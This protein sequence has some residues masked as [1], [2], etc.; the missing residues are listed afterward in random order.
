MTSAVAVPQSIPGLVT[1]D[2][3]VMTFLEGEQIT[4]LKV[5]ST[6]GIACIFL[7]FYAKFS[8]LLAPMLKLVL[9][10]LILPALHAYNIL[11]SVQ[12]F[13][14]CKVYCLL[15]YGPICFPCFADL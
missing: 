7:G 12:Y 9:C 4:R 1:K 8:I 11:L 2:I 10:I 6:L 5:H 3:L 14:L 13:Q 15:S